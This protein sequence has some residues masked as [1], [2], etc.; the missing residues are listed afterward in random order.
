MSDV[1][2]GYREF[3]LEPGRPMLRLWRLDGEG[4]QWLPETPGIWA[5]KSEGFPWRELFVWGDAGNRLLCSVHDAN[6]TARFSTYKSI[7]QFHADKAM[8]GQPPWKWV[9]TLGTSDPLPK[10]FGP[11]VADYIARLEAGKGETTNERLDSDDAKV[12]D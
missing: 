11:C 12:S 10:P 8:D 2:T 5:F 1:S 4:W 6:A 9:R 7:R 3:L